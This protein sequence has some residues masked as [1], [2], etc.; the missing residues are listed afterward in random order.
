MS[1]GKPP[2]LSDKGVF[3]SSDFLEFLNRHGG[4]ELARLEVRT[5]SGDTISRTFHSRDGDDVFKSIDLIKD[6][7]PSDEGRPPHPMGHFTSGDW[8]VD[9]AAIPVLCTCENGCTEQNAHDQ[10]CLFHYLPLFCYG[11]I[12]PQTP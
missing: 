11:I 7:F 2:A 12:K 6:F 10:L 8:T 4:P 5:K 3:T 1:D 9:F